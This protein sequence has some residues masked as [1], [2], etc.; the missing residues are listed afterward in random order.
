MGITHL[1]NVSG[2]G[3]SDG[4]YRKYFDCSISEQEEKVDILNLTKQLIIIISAHY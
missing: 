2:G 3:R 4:C 1:K